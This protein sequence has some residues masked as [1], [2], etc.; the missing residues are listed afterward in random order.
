METAV[1]LEEAAAKPA[2]A[3][4]DA[5]A[6]SA[7]APEKALPEPV[8]VLADAMALEAAMAFEMSA[9]LEDVTTGESIVLLEPAIT[10]DVTM[11]FVAGGQKLN[12][13]GRPDNV[14]AG[15]MRGASLAGGRRLNGE[16]NAQQKP[17]RD[18]RCDQDA[19]DNEG[20]PGGGTRY[21]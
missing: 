15:K 10:F 2:M 18:G 7:M 20:L 8:A 1:T 13:L 19:R 16:T 12:R 9:L 3:P 6:K 21:L 5:A 14:R 4:E 17:K 11:R